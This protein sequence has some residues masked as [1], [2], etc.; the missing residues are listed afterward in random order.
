[1]VI[2]GYLIITGIFIV[3]GTILAFKDYIIRFFNKIIIPTTLQIGFKLVKTINV[4]VQYIQD[5]INSKL[6]KLSN[7]SNY[8]KEF[9]KSI[10]MMLSKYTVINKSEVE[11]I[12]EIFNVDDGQLSK[13]KS[14]YIIDINSLPDHIKNR[15]KHEK[16]ITRYHDLDLIHEVKDN[17]KRSISN[18]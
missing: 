15:L 12:T 6:S 10:L 18:K 16:T 1:M 9:E 14:K 5:G 7:I 4:L 3:V 2:E 17:V 13:S 8:L 11:I